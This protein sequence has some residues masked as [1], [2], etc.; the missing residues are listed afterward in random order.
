MGSGI[1]D[2]RRV[3]LIRLAG[4]VSKG[5][6]VESALAR[7]AQVGFCSCCV[8]ATRSAVPLVFALGANSWVG[9]LGMGL[10]ALGVPWA[11]R[12]LAAVSYVLGDSGPPLPTGWDRAARSLEFVAPNPLTRSI[13]R[14]LPG[15]IPAI[16]DAERQMKSHD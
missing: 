9:D 6:D 10:W 8:K 15:P 4:S 11:G 2:A 12:R 16:T 14:G 5:S 3:I 1:C 13:S 7:K